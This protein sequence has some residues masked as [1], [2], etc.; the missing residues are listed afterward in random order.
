MVT[1]QNS[2]PAVMLQSLAHNKATLHHQQQKMQQLSSPLPP[3]HQRGSCSPCSFSTAVTLEIAQIPCRQQP[4][5]TQ[6]PDHSHGRLNDGVS[7]DNGRVKR[8][9]TSIRWPS[10]A[11]AGVTSGLIDFQATPRLELSTSELGGEDGSNCDGMRS[12]R[13]LGSDST[14]ANDNNIDSDE[15]DVLMS[16]R[17]R[18]Y[19]PT[20]R[21]GEGSLAVESSFEPRRRAYSR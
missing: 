18:A 5:E 15:G 11:I 21:E 6:Q 1:T 2:E 4:E 14:A 9:D 16:V 7:V 13:S 17:Q 10:A 12:Q 20:G 3:H 19:T 8:Q